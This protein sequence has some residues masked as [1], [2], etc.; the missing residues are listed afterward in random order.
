MQTRRR[1]VAADPSVLPIGSRIRVHDAGAYSGVYTVTDTGPGVNGRE[2][3]IFIA[4]SAEA[5][6]FGRRRLHVEILEP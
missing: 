3:D 1:I 2:I 5:H 6:R 4:D